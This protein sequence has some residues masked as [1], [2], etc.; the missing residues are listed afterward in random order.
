MVPSDPLLVVAPACD[1]GLGFALCLQLQEQ[2]ARFA[3]LYI[4]SLEEL[5]SRGARAAA[6]GDVDARPVS[7]CLDLVRLR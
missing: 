2:A 5:E 1:A 7:S 6:S 4:G 3:E